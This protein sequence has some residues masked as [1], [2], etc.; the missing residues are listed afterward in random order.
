[1]ER[2]GEGR[3]KRGRREREGKRWGE[4]KCKQG[5]GRF[6]DG[7]HEWGREGSGDCG[8]KVVIE[9]SGVSKSSRQGAKHRAGLWIFS[10]AV[11]VVGD[12]TVCWILWFPL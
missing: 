8:I 12:Y 3:W 5:K 6:V 2:E 7:S 9:E 11:L 4:R 1:V 10:G